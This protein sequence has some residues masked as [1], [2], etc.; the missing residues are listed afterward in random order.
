MTP[1]KASRHNYQ[2]DLDFRRTIQRVPIRQRPSLRTLLR[3]YRRHRSR[4]FLEI[5]PITGQ[6]RRL[7]H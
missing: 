3:R 1:T 4:I 2:L 5:D 6:W 7:G